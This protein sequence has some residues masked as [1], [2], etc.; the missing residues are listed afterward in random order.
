MRLSSTQLS[1]LLEGL[2]WRLALE[3]G[4]TATQLDNCWHHCGELNQVCRDR[5]KTVA[6]MTHLWVSSENLI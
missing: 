1:A 6:K 2:D 4:Q 5:R 3:M